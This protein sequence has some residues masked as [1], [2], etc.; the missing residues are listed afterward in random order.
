[1]TVIMPG[2]YQREMGMGEQVKVK[3]PQ[4]MF[5]AA[6]DCHNYI[7]DHRIIR[8]ELEA[9][10]RWLSENPIVPTKEQIDSMIGS[11]SQLHWGWDTYWREHTSAWITEWQRRMFL[12]PEPE[13]PEAI[14]DLLL[15]NIESG[16]FK[17]EI[18]NE[19]LA[20]AFWRGQKSGKP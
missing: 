16:F 14:K 9:A 2:D 6:M 19:R 10:L 3:V 18:V 1:M 11:N 17:P 13:V 7:P 15:P 4:G 8:K 20:E 5:N 12:T